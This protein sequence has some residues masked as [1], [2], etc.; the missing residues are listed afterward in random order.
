MAQKLR[1]V[2]RDGAFLPEAPVDLPNN[3]Q[4]NLLVEEATVLPPSVT[5]PK[6]R[7]RVLKRVTERMQDNPLPAG[8]PHL[9][10]DVLHE[11][12]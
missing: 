2:Y 1:A 9:S 7:Q 11:R 8:A 6:E 4:V 10:R 3:S 5:E 12:R